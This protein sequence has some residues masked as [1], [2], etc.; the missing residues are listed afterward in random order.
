MFKILID[1]SVK[2]ELNLCREIFRKIIKETTSTN[3]RQ[4]IS[5]IDSI[6]YSHQVSENIRKIET[7]DQKWS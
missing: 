2:F 6:I 7:N 3:S 5:N 4:L 1:E